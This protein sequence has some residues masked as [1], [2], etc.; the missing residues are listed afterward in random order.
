MPKGKGTAKAKVKAKPRAKKV[1]QLERTYIPE[2]DASSFPS[3]I[4]VAQVRCRR[5]SCAAVAP[6]KLTQ[7]QE[8]RAMWEVPSIAQL[9]WMLAKGLKYKCCSLKEL[10]VGILS[11]QT[12]DAMNSIGSRLVVAAQSDTKWINGNTWPGWDY[13]TWSDPLINT[14]SGMPGLRGIVCNL[15]DQMAALKEKHRVAKV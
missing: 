6:H 9:L 13:V 3:F 11:P 4:E 14:Q 7:V 1:I 15:F 8:V 10:E 5:G 12:S 2:D